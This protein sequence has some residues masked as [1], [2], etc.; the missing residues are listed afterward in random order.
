M[1]ESR[2]LLGYGGDGVA[3]HH[4]PGGGVYFGIYES[5]VSI[6]RRWRRESRL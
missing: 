6:K 4:G 1:D 5:E 3:W 2:Y